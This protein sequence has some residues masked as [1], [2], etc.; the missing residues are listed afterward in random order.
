MLLFS[1]AVSGWKRQL[2]RTIMIISVASLFS[3]LALTVTPN[4][5]EA[6]PASGRHDYKSSIDGTNLTCSIYTP[7]NRTKTTPLPVW[8]MLH[9]LG[10]P[11]PDYLQ[12]YQ[13]VANTYDVICITPNGRNYQSLYADGVPVTGEP[14]IMDD[15]S[16]GT[17][18]WA[19]KSGHWYI[20]TGQQYLVQDQNSQTFSVA[21]RTGS[22]GVE[23]AVSTDITVQSDSVPSYGGVSFRKQDDNNQ[24]WAG[25]LNDGTKKFGLC[26]E[27]N[28]VWTTLATNSDTS[29]TWSYNQPY[30]LKVLVYDDY[31]ELLVNNQ[32][33]ALTNSVHPQLA[34]YTDTGTTFRSGNA[35]LITYGSV[36]LFD[37]FKV[38]DEFQYGATDIT[39]TIQQFLDEFSVD[40]HYT[41]DPSKIY[42]GGYSMG[43][44]GTWSLGLQNPELFAALHPNQGTSDLTATYSWISAHYAERPIDQYAYPEQDVQIVETS[45]AI[46]GSDDP[47]NST[48]PRVMSGL[49][50]NSGRYLLENGLNTSIRIEDKC[51][52]TL[53]P[54]TTAP[55][56][57]DA[58]LAIRYLSTNPW[59]LY[60]DLDHYATGNAADNHGLPNPKP[61]YANGYYPWCQL[62]ITNM[63]KGTVETSR[64]DQN[65][66][67]PGTDYHILGDYF[68][69]FPYDNS[70]VYGAHGV[71]GA[72]TQTQ[73]LDTGP[74]YYAKQMGFFLNRALA[75]DKYYQHVD[76]GEV[77]YKTYDTT[78]NSAWWLTV[79]AA[80][81]NN[82]DY[83]G[84][85]RVKR[86]TA[87]NKVNVH[88][89]NVA[90]TTLDIKRMARVND[91]GTA[92][93]N[94]G[95]G[96]KLTIVVD[97]NTAPE[98]EP[99][100]DAAS[101]TN[102]KLVGEWYPALSYTI[103]KNGTTI[104]PAITGTTITI[105]G[106]TSSPTTT[107]EITMPSNQSGANLL[108]SLN[109]GFESGTQY[110]STF[111]NG[112]LNGT[113]D[114]NSM[115]CLAH[116]GN[117]SLRIK[118][119]IPSQS[120]YTSQWK[121][122]TP[123]SITANNNY[124]LSAFVDTRE[125]NSKSRVYEN[126]VYS[127]NDAYNSAVGIGIA[128]INSQGAQV[129]WTTGP[130]TRGTKEWVP[131]EVQGQ[132]PGT[133][134]KAQPILYV[135]NHDSQ[136]FSGSVW[137]DDV[138]LRRLN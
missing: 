28:G 64:F 60:M 35:G 79:V 126:G 38:Q 70:M 73:F 133:A 30:R 72:T 40:P 106:V 137:F 48:D 47:L 9:A 76:P 61:G 69:N 55:D 129:G 44:G 33:I 68:D 41:A 116:S 8:V 117:K 78:H 124:S 135:I 105:P 22:S 103:K 62:H 107:I 88:V 13:D 123:V 86:D 125:L 120:P 89:K 93:L 23:Y 32:I 84:L 11:S 54:N 7:Q 65:G 58:P 46:I 52:D 138:G 66:V 81:P 43:G 111:E 34:G 50:E 67:G 119:S 132:A 85:A 136:G 39:D 87:N 63:S 99:V 2:V 29:L 19:F 91:S 37:N 12:E 95:N 49:R 21:E 118:D 82:K 31:I 42:L 109:C 6:V 98:S 36:D 97:N 45:N 115:K 101:Q 96:Q 74:D 10:G 24:Y 71:G 5:A 59:T 128:W 53:I 94:L 25:L 80:Q 14:S 110:W 26:K 134:V 122:T 75:S 112:T 16:S 108:S 114:V 92:Q 3:F 4:K 17:T 27:V 113:Y 102:L 130:G 127:Q 1:K 90:T 77:A 20:P 15:F 131:M 100:S 104:T 56:N 57:G 51:R 121:L 83:P 18:G